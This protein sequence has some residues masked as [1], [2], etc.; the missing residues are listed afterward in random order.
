[1]PK[2]QVQFI[3]DTG[4]TLFSGAVTIDDTFQPRFF[5]AFSSLYGPVDSLAMNTDGTP[6]APPVMRAMTND[7]IFSKYAGGLMV[8][9]ICNIQ[10]AEKAAAQ[11][12]LI[13]VAVT[14]TPTT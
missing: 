2:A 12:A 5:A 7:E 13:P 1:M 14:F 9:T 6:V 3:D 4:G 8:G 11:A 10:N